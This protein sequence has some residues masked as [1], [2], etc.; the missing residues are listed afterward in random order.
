M[1]LEPISPQLSLLIKIDVES[2][3]PQVL[4]GAAET[5]LNRRPAILLEILPEADLEFYENWI[6]RHNYRHFQ[7]L[8]PNNVIF[9]NKIE[10]S[11]RHRDHLL[12]PEEYIFPF[13]NL[14]YRVAK[15]SPTLPIRLRLFD[16]LHLG[17]RFLGL[18]LRPRGVHYPL[19]LDLL[20]NALFPFLRLQ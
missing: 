4:Q 13:F 1:E 14:S 16:F 9:A 8:P 20:Q 7:L 10:A 5:I 3:E 2:F 18:P 19:R 15:P 17:Y 12:L 6:A 11:L